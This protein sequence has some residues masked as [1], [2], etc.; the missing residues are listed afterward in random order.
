[1]SESV[2]EYRL[3][4]EHERNEIKKIINVGKTLPR[5]TNRDGVDMGECQLTRRNGTRYIY[6]FSNPVRRPPETNAGPMLFHLCERE[7]TK[8][9]VLFES[10]TRKCTC[11]KISPKIPR[12]IFWYAIGKTAST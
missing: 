10:F 1:M 12:G 11:S 5:K 7:I 3:Y 6:K 2:C 9:T 4:T 8:V